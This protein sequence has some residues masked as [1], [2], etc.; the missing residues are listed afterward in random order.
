MPSHPMLYLFQN[1]MSHVMLLVSNIDALGTHPI[2]IGDV[3]H[4]LIATHPDKVGYAL[5]L[6]H[7][8]VNS[9]L[10]HKVTSRLIVR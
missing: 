4:G 2:Y 7:W 1:V 3:R 9:T 6:L 5:L 8:V 10:S